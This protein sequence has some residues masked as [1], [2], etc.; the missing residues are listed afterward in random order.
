M[1]IKLKHKI[2]SRRVLMAACIIFMSTWGSAVSHADEIKIGVVDTERVLA[3]SGT[4]VRA[5]R[6]LENE[7]LQR[8][9]E[10]KKMAAQ[11]KTL[12]DLLEK[13]GQSMPEAER[14]NKERDLATL[15]REY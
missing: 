10:L 2:H 9:Q 7:F 15:N 1:E 6:K 14:R 4:A 8:D 5:L 13:E 3:E 12:Q 11:A